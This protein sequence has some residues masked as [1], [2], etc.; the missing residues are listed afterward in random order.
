MNLIMT[1]G[2]LIKNS[3]IMRGLRIIRGEKYGKRE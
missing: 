2:M 1:M 3:K